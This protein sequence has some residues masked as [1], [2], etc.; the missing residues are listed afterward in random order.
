[1]E[2]TYG[3]IIA[4]FKHLN[5]YHVERLKLFSVAPKVRFR[6]TGWRVQEGSLSAQCKDERFST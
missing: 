6:T 4:V 3:D 1:M 2:K 5:G